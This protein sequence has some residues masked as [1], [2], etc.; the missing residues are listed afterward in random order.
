MLSAFFIPDFF[1]GVFAKNI[2]RY[3]NSYHKKYSRIA[4]DSAAVFFRKDNKNRSVLV[5]TK[6]VVKLIKIIIPR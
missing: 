1:L 3:R 4:I 6:T 2:T 5:F